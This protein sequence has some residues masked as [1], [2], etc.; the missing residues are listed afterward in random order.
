MTFTDHRFQPQIM[1]FFQ[2]KDSKAIQDM[3]STSHS[4]FKKQ[5]FRLFNP[6]GT[7]KI[8]QRINNIDWIYGN[9][10]TKLVKK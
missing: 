5:V 9:Q 3:A 2:P 1:L 6:S 7:V 4:V 10:N 8:Y